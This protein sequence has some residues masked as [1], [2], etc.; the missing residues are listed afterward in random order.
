MVTSQEN[1]YLDISSALSDTE[2]IGSVKLRI[3][4]DTGLLYL[5]NIIL[6]LPVFERANALWIVYLTLKKINS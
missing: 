5:I 3:Y 1:C 2:P 4:T 6:K